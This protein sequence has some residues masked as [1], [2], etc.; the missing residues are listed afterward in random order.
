RCAS[1]LKRDG[2][3]RGHLVET[4]FKLVAPAFMPDDDFTEPPLPNDHVA[5]T[6]LFPAKPEIAI[7]TVVA[8][9]ATEIATVPVA[10]ARSHAQIQLCQRRLGLRAEGR[11]C[12]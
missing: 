1:D 8:I 5:A 4:D 10:A 9:E 6:S 3:S 7:I 11:A 2:P 12:P